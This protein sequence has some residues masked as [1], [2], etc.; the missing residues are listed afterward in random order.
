[1]DKEKP[2]VNHNIVC[3][4]VGSEKVL[5]NPS[6]D[7]VHFL[8]QTS[9][10]IWELCDGGH[11]IADI[12]RAIRHKFLVPKNADVLGDIKRMLNGFRKQGLLKDAD[13]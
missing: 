1:M 13:V 4:T 5:Y 8:N 10:L 6:K 3:K 9:A 12:E 2:C 11:T 7:A